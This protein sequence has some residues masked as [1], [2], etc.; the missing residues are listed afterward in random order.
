MSDPKRSASKRE[1]CEADMRHHG[2]HVWERKT[3]FS[4]HVG[5]GNKIITD[6]DI[7]CRDCGE[8][9]NMVC[10]TPIESV[11]PWVRSASSIA[12]IELTE[13]MTEQSLQEPHTPLGNTDEEE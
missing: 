13:P 7:V 6:L 3:L 9:R 2:G 1:K 5:V 8:R 12:G 11:P 10:S 4:V